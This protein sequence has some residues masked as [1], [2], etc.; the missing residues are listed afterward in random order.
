MAGR[1]SGRRARGRLREARH[2]GGPGRRRV[3][4]FFNWAADTLE[5]YLLI[6]FNVQIVKPSNVS[7][8]S[9]TSKPSC[10]AKNSRYP[11]SNVR[12]MKRSEDKVRGGPDV[13]RRLGR[14]RGRRPGPREARLAAGLRLPLRRGLARRVRATRHT[15][16]ASLTFFFHSCSASTVDQKACVMYTRITF[17]TSP[18]ESKIVKRRLWKV[19]ESICNC[20]QTSDEQ[21]LVPS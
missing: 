5:V 4:G 1:V 16:R 13:G 8:R 3:R 7:I 21:T 9:D 14:P 19:P 17:L 11:I 15:T 6:L 2:A 10:S 18:F 20:G 12:S